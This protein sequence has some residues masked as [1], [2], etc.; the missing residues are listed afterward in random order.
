IDEKSMVQDSKKC[1][2]L[3]IKTVLPGH[4]KIFSNLGPL[5]SHRL[6][7]QEK[8][9]HDVFALLQDKP[10]T[11]YEICRKILPKQYKTQLDLTLSE[12]I[13]QLDFL[14]HNGYVNKT[15]VDETLVY[16]VKE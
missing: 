1:F 15:I 6:L 2:H 16:N 9:A 14:E 5:I 4:G 10:Q 3:G 13:G 11:P 8:R 12:T 7:K